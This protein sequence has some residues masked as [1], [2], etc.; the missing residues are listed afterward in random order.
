M[1]SS[2]P[3]TSASHPVL[4]VHD[5]RVSFHV[6]DGVV[7]AVDGLS[8]TVG[9]GETLGLIGESGCGKTVTAQAILR[10][11]PETGRLV[12]GRILLRRDTD[13]VDLAGLESDGEAMRQIRGRDLGVV[14][15]EPAAS[16]TPGLTIGD[17]L[18]ELIQLHLG[19]GRGERDARAFDILARVGMPDPA[20][21]ADAFP[22]QLSGGLQQ[23]A[24]IALA[25]CCGPR[26]LIA[27]EPTTALDTIR[28]A[29]ILDLLRALQAENG[30]A[31][32]HITHDLGLV[33]RAC[34]RVAVMYLGRIVECAS[35]AALLERPLHPYT[36]QLL[37]SRPVLRR[38]AARLDAIAG[39]VPVPVGLPAQCGFYD[40]CPEG[41]GG[42]CD[43]AVPALVEVEPDHWVRCYLHSP[44]T[45]DQGLPHA[46]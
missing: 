7:E 23:R 32:L 19:A 31:V 37:K 21:Q 20:V 4:E 46:G 24:T 9:P 33:A 43:V 29:Q 14:F 28:Q 5:L 2:H 18:R 1:S 15:Q 34:D 17:Q 6:P 8:L 25:L 39:T 10:T 3:A 16:L 36:V 38:R 30:M 27:D 40:R 44:L 11:L 13:T 26:L 41:E 35:A 42:R 45:E 12:S 22:H